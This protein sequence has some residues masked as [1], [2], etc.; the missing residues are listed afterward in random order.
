MPPSPGLSPSMT[1]RV[2]H[3]AM[4]AGVAMFLLVAQITGG[5]VSPP[6]LKSALPLVLVGLGVPPFGAAAVL[7]GRLPGRGGGASEDDWWRANQ[8]RVI[9]VWALV[10]APSLLGTV[11]YFLTRDSRALV[12]TLVGLVLFIQFR[13]G[14]LAAR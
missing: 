3:G 8:A 9:V 5:D 7:A 11:F 13:P 12:A 2:I 14:R 1:A 6:A 4:L 10:E